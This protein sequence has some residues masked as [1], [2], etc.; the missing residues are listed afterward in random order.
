[1]REA[2]T[3]TFIV[4][5]GFSCR[6]QIAQ[7]TERRAM[8]LAEVVRLALHPEQQAAEPLA[9]ARFASARRERAA[10]P[11]PRELLLLGMLA[12]ATIAGGRAIWRRM[13]ADR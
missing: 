12:G 13:G 2:D 3:G 4:A 1:V 8:H 7:L 10:A 5:D 11:E 9:E 6:E